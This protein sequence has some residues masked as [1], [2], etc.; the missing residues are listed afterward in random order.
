MAGVGASMGAMG[1]SPEMEEGERGRRCEAP[2]GEVGLQQG[3]HREGSVLLLLFVSCCALYR[4]LYPVPTSSDS[5][6]FQ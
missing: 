3:R 1:S 2:W 4:G 5:I 6:T